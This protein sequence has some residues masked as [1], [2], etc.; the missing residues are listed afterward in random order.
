HKTMLPEVRQTSEVYA[1]TVD[2]HFFGYEI[3]I[4]GIAGDQQAALFGQACFDEGMAKNTYG[5]GC[6]MLMNTGEKGISSDNGLL[7]TLAWGVDGKVEY[8]LEGSIFVAGSA[9]QWLRDGLKLI[10]TAPESE[11]FAEKVDSADGV[12]V[13]PAF[14]GLGTPYW[15]SDARGAVF[16]LTRGTTKA[17]FIRAT[18]ESLAYQTK[19]VLDVMIEDSGI[20]LKS[21]RVDGGAVKNNLLMQFQ[22]DM[23]GVPVER[24]IVQ[25]TTALGAAYLAGLAVG[26]WESKE[27]IQKH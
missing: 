2:Y 10:E 21:L 19:D 20:D 27:A 18:L 7:T 13:V 22:S 6:F 26:F 25:E 1:T 17:H 16:G 15:D 9:I 5:T 24:P 4:A 14:V 11:D 12:Y 23:L 3:P 8:A